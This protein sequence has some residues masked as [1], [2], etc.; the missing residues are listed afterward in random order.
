MKLLSDSYGD[1]IYST[2]ISNIGNVTLPKGMA[3]VVERLDFHLSPSKTNKTSCAAIG[4]N[5]Y[6]N[7]NFTSIFANKTDLERETLRAL[8]QKG[9]PVEVATNRRVTT[10]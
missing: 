2:T 10:D 8:V 4:A 9:I 6:L 1:A 3:E 7:L 5:G